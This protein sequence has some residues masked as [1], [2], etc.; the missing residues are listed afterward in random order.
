MRNTCCMPVCNSGYRSNKNGKTVA[1]FQFPINSDLCDKLYRAIKK[2]TGK[3]Q[4]LINFCKAL[5]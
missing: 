2:K 3:Y 4:N 1:L 5:S